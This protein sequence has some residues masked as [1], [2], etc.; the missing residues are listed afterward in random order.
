MEICLKDTPQRGTR[1][2]AHSQTRQAYAMTI[3][4]SKPI[5]VSDG[6]VDAEIF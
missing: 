6:R 2:H 3:T 5:T 4:E 1:T